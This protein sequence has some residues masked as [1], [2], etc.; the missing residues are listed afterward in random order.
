MEGARAEDAE[1]AEHAESEQP[2]VSAEDAE[3]AVGAGALAEDAGSKIRSRKCSILPG[4]MCSWRR[5][6]ARQVGGRL[7]LRT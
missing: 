2:A 1:D 3:D 5:K 6:L 4:R 7:C